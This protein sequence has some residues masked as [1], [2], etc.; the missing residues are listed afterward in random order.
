M[1]HS[2]G[3]SPS[4]VTGVPLISGTLALGVIQPH[5]LERRMPSTMDPRPTAE[6]TAPPVSSLFL[7]PCTAGMIRRKSRM[8]S[9]TTD[10]AAKT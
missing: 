6:S 4:G 7:R 9:T 2:V 10:S 5:W 8:M 3:D 1:S